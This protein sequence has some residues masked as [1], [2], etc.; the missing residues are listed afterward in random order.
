MPKKSSKSPKVLTSFNNQLHL[1]VLEF[2]LKRV[3]VRCSM[4]V[5]VVF[6]A[7]SV[8]SFGPILDL[9]GGSTL[10]LTS[11]IF[12]CIFWLYLSAKDKKSN[13]KQNSDDQSITLREVWDSSDRITLGI[14][15]LIIGMLKEIDKIGSV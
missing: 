4:M 7:E 5:A 12:P 3:I 13:G 14:C 8:P 9:V 2:C 10:T 1:C 11:I 6:A 15:L